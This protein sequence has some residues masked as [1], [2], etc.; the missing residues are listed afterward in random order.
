VVKAA[1]DGLRKL[2]S[3]EEAARLRGRDLADI[4]AEQGA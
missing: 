1:L 4:R 2:R 3:P